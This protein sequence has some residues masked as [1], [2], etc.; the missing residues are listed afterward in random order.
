M[1]ASIKTTIIKPNDHVSQNTY[2]ELSKERTLKSFI[3]RH[4]AHRMV[5]SVMFTSD[6]QQN[7]AI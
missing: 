6:V 5:K 1:T 4:V 2:C 3:K 7:A